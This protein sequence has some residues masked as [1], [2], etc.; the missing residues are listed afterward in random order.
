MQVERFSLPLQT[1]ETINESRAT[2]S[3]DR[4]SL[5]GD[6]SALGHERRNLLVWGDNKL[7]MSSLLHEHAGQIK[8]IY[9]DPPFATGDDFSVRLQVGDANFVKQPSILEEHAYRDTWQAGYPSYLSMMYERLVLIRD[10]LADDGTC[11]VHCDWH[12]NSYL[13]LV[14]DEVFGAEKVHG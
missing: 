2:R 4:G 12:V 6:D 7:V 5:F 8:L 3:R 1:V 9:I 10:L 13:R 14:L 11:Y